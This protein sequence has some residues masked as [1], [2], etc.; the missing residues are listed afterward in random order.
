MN[1]SKVYRAEGNIIGYLWSGG[2]A[3]YPAGLYRGASLE[4]LRSSIQAA[5]N[6]E[7][8]CSWG[9]FETLIVAVM[10]IS[11]VSTVEVGGKNFMR[12]DSKGVET[13]FH[14]RIIPCD[15]EKWEQTIRERNL[16]L[17]DCIC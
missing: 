9:D 13:F 14:P 11:A 7:R 1:I 4:E 6:N 8:Y 5:V 15:Y 2:L 3:S 17:L 10:L 16:H 12:E